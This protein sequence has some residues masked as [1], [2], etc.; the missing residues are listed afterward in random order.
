MQ[1]NSPKAEVLGAVQRASAR[2][3]LAVHLEMKRG[4]YS[5]ASIAF[6][7]P[8]VGV[9]GTL[10]GIVGSFRGISS[11][12]W[13]EYADI[14]NGL[15]QS[16]VPAALGILVA[17]VAFCG[18]RYFLGRLDDFDVEMEIASLQLLEQLAS[19]SC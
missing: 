11:G 10:W 15:S 4:L 19:V 14:V 8:L 13:S 12:I 5:L 9:L 18:H 1:S 17:V 16:L 3:A 7:A 6:S 2:A